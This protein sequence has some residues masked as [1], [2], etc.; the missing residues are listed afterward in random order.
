MY[1]ARIPYTKEK[2]VTFDGPVAAQR[3]MAG[4]E[5]PATKDV[6]IAALQRHGAPH[7]LIESVN[8]DG[9]SRFVSPAAVSQ[10]WWNKQDG[11]TAETSRYQ[12]AALHR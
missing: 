6:V 12:P 2:H 3:Y 1:S 8:A 4:V 10:L 7:D 5:W 9:K 11:R